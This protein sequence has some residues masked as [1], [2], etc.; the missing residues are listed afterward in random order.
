MTCL[1]SLFLL[2]M[3]FVCPILADH[4]LGFIDKF[5]SVTIT[6]LC[7]EPGLFRAMVDFYR[8]QESPVDEAWC[9]LV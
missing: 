8:C 7:F 6:G 3:Y 5:T 9:S 4:L 2:C 1:F